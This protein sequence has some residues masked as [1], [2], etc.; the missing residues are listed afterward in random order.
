MFLTALALVLCVRMLRRR[1]FG[2]GSAAVLG[3]TLGAGQLVRAFSLW[4]LA[5]VVVTLA[6]AALAGYADRRTVARTITV[7]VIVSALVAGPWYLRQGLRYSNPIFDRPTAAVP[8][9]RRRPIPFY[10]GLGLPALFTHPAR[11][12]FV[13]QAMPTTYSELW[14]DWEGYFAWGYGKPPAP[15]PNGRLAAQNMLGLVPTA[16]AI[17]GCLILLAGTLRRY[18][19]AHDPAPLVIALLPPTALLGYLYFTVGYPTPTGNVLKASYMLTAAPAWAIA[20][21]SALERIPRRR[22]ITLTLTALLMFALVV[23]VP[24]LFYRI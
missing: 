11:P 12:S 8:L 20:F 16:L 10:V 23:D 14:G 4:T 17:A 13:N 18:R 24:F 3:L 6:A 19:L 7:V 22:L 5:V 9:W 2:S 15:P 1:S 21:G